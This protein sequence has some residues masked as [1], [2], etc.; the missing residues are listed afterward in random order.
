M[1]RRGRGSGGKAPF[2]HVASLWGYLVDPYADSKRGTE[3]EVTMGAHRAAPRLAVLP[4]DS[5]FLGTVSCVW[6]HFRWAHLGVGVHS[7]HLVHTARGM[8][9]NIPKVPDSLPQ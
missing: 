4:Q 7:W 6:R 3:T 2:L 1:P 9:L 5:G 8:L